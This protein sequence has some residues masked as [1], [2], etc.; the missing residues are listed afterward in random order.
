MGDLIGAFRRR[1]DIVDRPAQRRSLFG[2][3]IQM[4]CDRTAARPRSQPVLESLCGVRLQPFDDGLI[5]F[6]SSVA[7]RMTCSPIHDVSG[8]E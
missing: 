1:F 2:C 7:A 3:Y 5:K 6:A 8:A 4:I